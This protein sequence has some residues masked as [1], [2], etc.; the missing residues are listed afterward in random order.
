[1]TDTDFPETLADLLLLGALPQRPQRVQ[2]RH[3]LSSPLKGSGGSGAGGGAP[4]PALHAGLVAE[5]SAVDAMF[6]Q[7]SQDAAAKRRAAVTAR[8]FVDD[9]AFSL[10]LVVLNRRGEVRRGARAAQ[11]FYFVPRQAAQQAGELPCAR[12]CVHIRRHEMYFVDRAAAAWHLSD[13]V[14]RPCMLCLMRGLLG[15]DDDAI[16]SEAQGIL[17]SA[18][19]PCI[20]PTRAQALGPPAWLLAEL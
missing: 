2:G 18:W 15:D 1:M 16:L 6:R 7:W 4:K 17:H 14:C 11:Q 19:R 10:A 9:C 12:C 20:N 5:L 13:E 3:K 8:D